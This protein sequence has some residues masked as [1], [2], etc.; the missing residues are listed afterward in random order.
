M[1]HGVSLGSNLGDRLAWLQQARDCIGALT[2][3]R[4]LAQSAVYETEPVA[5]ESAYRQD[6]FLNAVL[7]ADTEMDPLDFARHLHDLEDRLGRVRQADR[8]APRVI[9][10]D[11]IYADGLQRDDPE[12]TLPHPRWAERRFVVQPLAE[13][14]P[15]LQLPGAARC[16]A[17]T[18]LALPP[19]PAANVYRQRW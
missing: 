4:V 18:L 17:E 6:F 12:L 9:D 7:I 2:G 3:V 10:L 14:R 19:R 8:N 1:E 11:M 5:M 13:V 15:K 16:V